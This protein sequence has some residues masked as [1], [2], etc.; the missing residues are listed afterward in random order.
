[1]QKSKNL[2]AITL[3]IL[4]VL[5]VV[6]QLWYW[7]QLQ[8]QVATHFDVHG[9]PDG[10]MSKNAATAT[11]LAMQIC[12]P[13]FLA[14]ISWLICH[15][16]YQLVNIP[17]RKYW[18]HVDRRV[19]SLKFL[20]TLLLW[21]ADSTALFLAAIG[22]L[23]FRAN[24]AGNGLELWLFVPAFVTFLFSIF[25]MLGLILWRFRKPSRIEALEEAGQWRQE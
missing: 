24:V 14:S 1:M 21:M 13:I 20:Q 8:A 4:L 22:H 23:T 25:L 18:L 5:A 15:L 10:W 11:M 19:A 17:N 6:Q 12:L 2:A 7:T 9:Q 16:P 3:T